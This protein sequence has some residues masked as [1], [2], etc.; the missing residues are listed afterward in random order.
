M[1]AHS[2]II[3]ISDIHLF[4]QAE[5]SLLGVN[6][7]MSFL[8]VLE[9]LKK[10][11]QNIDAII[12]SGDLSQDNSVASYHRL[13]EAFD[14]F[15]LPIYYV[16]GNH[17]D[18]S[19]LSK[20]FPRGNIQ[21]QKAIVF[22]DWQFI[23]LD[24]YKSHAVEGYFSDEQCRLLEQALKAHPK[25]RAIVVLHH[26][27]V[28][29]GSAWL[30]K[31]GLTNADDFWKCLAQYPQVHTVLFGHVHQ[32]YEGKKN[33]IHLY[34]TPSCCIQFKPNSHDFALDNIPPGYRQIDLYPN[35]DLKTQ[36]FRL[37]HYIGEFEANAKGY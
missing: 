11:S 25:H 1:V 6:T 27:P 28:P 5:K 34:S 10:E 26:Q 20:V 12:L 9:H 32:Q 24:S 22:N 8:A 4:D 13:A 37:P 16:P 21:S 18:P 33:G 30:D 31:I 29:V 36:V 35:G 7:Q 15:K 3:Q 17:D 14:I 19:T 2:R 23:L